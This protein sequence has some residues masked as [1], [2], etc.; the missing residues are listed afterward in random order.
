M[1]PE[2]LFK[3][4]SDTTNAEAWREFCGRYDGLIRK[5]IRRMLA[6]APLSGDIL[7]D[8]VQE[9]YVRLARNGCRALADF[10]MKGP[11]TDF[12]L[13][14]C[15]AVSTVLDHFKC[16]SIP[17][18]SFEEAG[19][20][21]TEEPD[22]ERGLFLE[23]CFRA[24]TEKGSNRDRD[25]RIFLLYFRLGLKAREIA[26]LRNIGLETKGVESVIHKTVSV[27]KKRLQLE[28]KKVKD[29]KADSDTVEEPA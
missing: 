8:L 23:Q 29:K 7:E 5:T 1:T 16:N 22:I 28:P 26:A 10:R 18:I 21:I 25:R 12:G 17:M 2:D 27:I 24:A 4:C 6:R 13:V 14:K 19:N 11:N 20:S 9:T 3:A 15:V